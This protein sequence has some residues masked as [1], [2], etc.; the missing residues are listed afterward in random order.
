MHLCV[1]PFFSSPQFNAR[2]KRISLAH[3]CLTSRRPFRKQPE[4]GRYQLAE[5]WN[6]EFQVL[7]ARFITLRIRAYSL[8][9]HPLILSKPAL[10]SAAVWYD[11]GSSLPDEV[12]RPLGSKLEFALLWRMVTSEDYVGS[13]GRV[14]K[15]ML[16]NVRIASTGVSTS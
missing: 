8:L 9:P 2:Y 10:F 3:W 1:F 13:K 5:V 15:Q 11:D 14:E 12:H 6:R 16:L 4:V 7:I